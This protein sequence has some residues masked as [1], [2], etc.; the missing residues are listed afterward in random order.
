MSSLTRLQ[1][2]LR[3]MTNE[4]VANCSASIVNDNF[5]EWEAILIGP[6]DTPYENGIFKLKLHIPNDYPFKPPQVRFMTKIYHP[7]INSSGQICLDIL[8][9]Q[10][11]PSLTISKLLLSLLALMD[12][13]NPDDPLVLEVARQMKTNRE[14]YYQTAR[15]WTLQYANE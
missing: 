9:T 14:S 10:W 13:P 5:Y 3:M 2:E 12:Q 4:P 15:N 6:R 11:S 7:N 1:K 8:K